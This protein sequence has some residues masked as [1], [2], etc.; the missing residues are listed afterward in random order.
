M[1]EPAVL[2][3]ALEHQV[4]GHQAAVEQLAAYLSRALRRLGSVRGPLGSL[5]VVGPRGCGKRHLI[6]SAARIVLGGEDELIVQDAALFE[7]TSA[8]LER[9]LAQVLA[10]RVGRPVL[11]MVLLDN[12]DR[13]AEPVPASASRA[14]D[15]RLDRRPRDGAR[16]LGDA[17]P[18]APVSRRPPAV[19]GAPSGVAPGHART[20]AAERQRW[21]GRAVRRD[22]P[23]RR[24]SAGRCDRTLGGLERAR[25][26]PLE[27][28]GATANR[29]S[30]SAYVL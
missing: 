19:P 17:P 15:Q 27:K 2:R 10:P 8:L 20:A 12:I 26:L 7:R 1:I 30:K 29:M 22:G 25:A 21:E 9:L 4:V 6:R 28:G 16:G 11:R 3:Q 14:E 5:L 23:R 24:E 18:H 13:A